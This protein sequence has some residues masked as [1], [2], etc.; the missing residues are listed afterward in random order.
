MITLKNT[1][2]IEIRLNKKDGTYH[3]Y[4]VNPDSEDIFRTFDDDNIIPLAET[5]I[6]FD[7]GK[8]IP[9]ANVQEYIN[10]WRETPE[11]K[12]AIEDYKNEATRTI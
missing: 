8:I 10:A 3:R 1:G 7:N 5:A 2:H 4:V 9:N 6:I 12:Q 11:I